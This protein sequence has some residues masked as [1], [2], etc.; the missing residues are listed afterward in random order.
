M[1]ADY[2]PEIAEH[3]P[4]D[5]DF[6][7]IMAYGTA[8]SAPTTETPTMMPSPFRARPGHV[9]AQLPLVALPTAARCA[10]LFVSDQLRRW[11]LHELD[12]TATLVACELVTNAVAATGTLEMPA[13][14]AVLHD[15]DLAVMAMRL[16][17]TPGS[18]FVEVWDRDPNPPIPGNAGDFDENGRGLTLVTALTKTWGAYPTDTTAGGKVVWAEIN[19]PAEGTGARYSRAR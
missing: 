15:L 1:N 12:D 10:R 5:A 3:R 13:T 7:R 2:V 11:H 14:Y 17:L 16:L 9:S 19:I 6:A 18:L 8:P 4:R